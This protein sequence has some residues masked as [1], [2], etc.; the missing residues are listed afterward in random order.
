MFVPSA[1]LASL[2]LLVSGALFGYS[3]F[4]QRRY[5]A[6]LEA[7]TVR[8]EPQ[9]K[10]IAELDKALQVSRARA[11]ILDEFRSR[12]KYDLDT[13]NEL[14]KLLVPPDLVKRHRNDARR[15]DGNQRRSRTSGAASEADRQL[16]VL[17][18]FGVC[19]SDSQRHEYGNVPYP[20]A[21]KA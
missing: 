5:L 3:R 21:E 20:R 7:A 9:V 1:I 14:T 17:P 15:G 18:R 11:Q 8:I 2:L 19:H 16:A 12:S 13:L 4:E 10:K 6:E